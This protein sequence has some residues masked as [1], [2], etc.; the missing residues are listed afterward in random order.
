ME[1]CDL[2]DENRIPTGEIHERGERLPQGK[3]RLV[4][5]VCLFNE[6]NEMLIQLRAKEKRAWPD[7][8]DV[9]AGGCAQCGEDSRTAAT[10]ETREELGLQIDLAGKRPHLTCNFP[11]GFDDIY[12]TQIRSDSIKRLRLQA[13]EVRDARWASEKEIL[14]LRSAGKFIPYRRGFIELLFSI[15]EGFGS[16]CV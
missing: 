4:V 9:S 6:R 11:G 3:Y 2:Y 8:W 16:I 15:R 5:H 14:G 10:R 12:L 1:L 7:L 13:D